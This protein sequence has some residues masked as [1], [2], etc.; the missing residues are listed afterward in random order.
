MSNDF[1]EIR[2]FL[3]LTQH[4]LDTWKLIKEDVGVGPYSYTINGSGRSWNSYG[5]DTRKISKA[6]K[7]LI[8]RLF[9]VALNY[10]MDKFGEPTNKTAMID[11]VELAEAK[12]LFNN[13]NYNKKYMDVPPTVRLQML[14]VFFARDALA[15]HRMPIDPKNIFVTSHGAKVNVW[16]KFADLYQNLI[17]A[18]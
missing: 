17:L 5:V 7:D 4:C 9:A 15:L 11:P 14:V 8:N 3:S 1:A 2:K 12:E 18:A 16:H 13:R 10:G 6:D